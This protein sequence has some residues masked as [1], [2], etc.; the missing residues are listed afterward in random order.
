[1]T[2][3]APSP[4]PP[5]PLDSPRTMR[6]LVVS[7]VH[8]A[9]PAEKAR[10]GYESRALR[11]RLLRLAVAA[12]R[13]HFWL[14][15]PFAHNLL[16]DD[17]LARAGDADL[18]IGNG[19][20]SCDTGFVGV[21]DDA[22]AESAALCLGRLRAAW[23]DRFQPVLGDHE[24]G[25]FSIFGAC[26]GF[27]LASW[28]R[29]VGE[30]GFAPFW[31]RRV[32]DYSL[33]GLTSSLLAFP[34]YEPE[35]LPEERPRWRALRAQHLGA[36]R[37]ALEAVPDDRR[38]VL[39]LHDPTAL[40]FLWEELAVRRRA[41]QLE[42]TIVGHLHS[43]FILRTSLRLAGLPR[44]T[45]LGHSVRRMSEG[46]RRARSWKRF[47][48]Q[49]CPSLA[50]LEW[51]HDGGFLELTADHAPGSPLSIRSHRLPRHP[52]TPKPAA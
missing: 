46:L 34:V 38:I 6:I 11:S 49:L 48:V 41:A 24:L 51:F 32:G 10:R 52:E 39:F 50:G 22:A 42:A 29:C 40:P 8:Y 31:H 44:I 12:Y 4:E 9:S 45:F 36:I 37:D 18:V 27:R 2:P 43:P 7:D 1:M 5:P 25:K 33:L 16:L 17:F 30:F 26:G 23:G 21:S 15:D 35:A 28:D 14:R 20:Y 19:D 13:H 3:A 47:R